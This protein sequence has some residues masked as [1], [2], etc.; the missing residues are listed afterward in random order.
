MQDIGPLCEALHFAGYKI[1][2]ETNGTLPFPENVWIDW[3][4]IS[5]KLLPDE[6]WQNGV[7]VCT[8]TR[9]R[10]NELK[11]VVGTWRDVAAINLWLPM[12]YKGGSTPII[13][14]QPKSQGK[15]A[16]RVAYEACTMYNYRL[17]IQVHKYIDIR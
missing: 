14:L 17:S 6:R 4:C 3:V 1:A 7:Q 16:T 15:E 2:L 8:E 5:P 9:D 13:C 11:F 10:A 12:T